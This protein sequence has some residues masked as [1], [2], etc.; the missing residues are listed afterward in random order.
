MQILNTVHLL[1]DCWLL[2]FLAHLNV[3]LL[4]KHLMSWI[5]RFSDYLSDLCLRK[6]RWVVFID[7]GYRQFDVLSF[8]H[9][10][11]EFFDILALKGVLVFIGQWISD[12]QAFDLLRPYYQFESVEK[13]RILFEI[14]F[15]S[16][17][18]GVDLICL[19]WL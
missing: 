9:V 7:K 15:L 1:S 10:L 11:Y 19:Q 5:N 3:F 2:D 4:C 8:P 18:L 6:L 12:N 14:I 13:L 16:E 17:K